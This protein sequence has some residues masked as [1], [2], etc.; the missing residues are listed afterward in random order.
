MLYFLG[1]LHCLPVSLVM[2]SFV[3]IL[4]LFRQAEPLSTSSDLIF[5]V[6]LKHDRW[7]Y[8]NMFKAR[9]W[10]GFSLGNCAFVSDQSSLKTIIHEKRHCLQNY[11]FGVLFLIFYLLISLFIYVFLKSKHFYFDNQFEIDARRAADQS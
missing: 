4:R 11:L 3:L 2:W 8:K 7:F 9:G 5:V 1:F 6:K 10:A